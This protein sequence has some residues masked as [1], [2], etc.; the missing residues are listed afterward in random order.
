L[1]ETH[2]TFTANPMNSDRLKIELIEW[3]T[4]LEDSAVLTSLLQFK[5]A[6]QR[7]DWADNLTEGQRESLQRGLLDQ[8]EKNVI[9]SQ[10]F[11]KSYGREV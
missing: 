6:S 10:D 5:K 11:W 2:L 9:P 1:S 8:Q 7:G 4:R 3:L